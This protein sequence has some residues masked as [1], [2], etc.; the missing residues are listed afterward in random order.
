[1]ASV[2]VM[3][4]VYNGEKYLAQQVESILAQQDVEV[5]IYIRDDGSDEPTRGMLEKYAAD[6]PNIVV[7]H[8][9]NL[10]IKDS[11]LQIVRD[12]PL[13]HEY[14]AFS[15]A[16][17]V[18]LPEK[19]TAAVTLLGAQD[20]TV[21]HAYCSQITLVDAKLDFIGYGRGLYRPISFANAIVE[22]RLSGATAVFNRKLIT[23]AREFDYS[24]AVM[25]DSWMGLVAAGFGEVHFDP[26]SH[27]LYRQHGN[28]AE[29][30][31]WSLAQTWG[32][33]LKRSSLFARFAQQANGFLTQAA[34]KLSA[35]KEATLVRLA[36]YDKRELSAISFLFDRGI[37]YQR[38][39]SKIVTALSLMSSK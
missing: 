3:M 13:A 9:K 35:D 27:I 21:A 26:T 7:T 12:V 19:L 32:A 5:T 36:R 39:L 37:E 29:G 17:D 1:M 8:G 20:P 28:N 38:S 11:F 25:H 31:K 6:H 24:S 18:W 30:G 23:I 22:C 10:G 34:G 2:A 16:D 4:S 33:R 15:D 14:Y